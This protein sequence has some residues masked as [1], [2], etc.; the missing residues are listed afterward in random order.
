VVRP[1]TSPRRHV[2]AGLR[3]DP[4]PDDAVRTS[5]LRPADESRRYA[6]SL[7]GGTGSPPV[8][9]LVRWR[10]L[11]PVI[12]R[13]PS[14]HVHGIETGH[15]FKAGPACRHRRRS[16]RGGAGIQDEPSRGARGG[17]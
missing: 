8:P 1:R 4:E 12:R 17:R 11:R 7:S 5:I 16:G 10:R 13:R 2:G 6:S 15:A 3:R 14:R 9:D